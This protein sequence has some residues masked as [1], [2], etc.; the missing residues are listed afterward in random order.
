MMSVIIFQPYD[1]LS[2]IPVIEGA[3]GVITDWKGHHLNWE[4]SSDS[5]APSKVFCVAHFMSCLLY[6]YHVKNVS[7]TYLKHQGTTFVLIGFNFDSP[8][9]ITH[10]TKILIS[11]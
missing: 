11:M 1:F 2:L 6:L 8:H 5:R 10:F 9:L 4:A 3:G 7:Q